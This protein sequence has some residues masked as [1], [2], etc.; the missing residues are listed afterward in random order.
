MTIA[1]R[2]NHGFSPR[3]VES[4]KLHF[5]HHDSPRRPPP[6]SAT[7]LSPSPTAIR[8]VGPAS[9]YPRLGRLSILHP[10]SDL[11]VFRN[12]RLIEGAEQTLQKRRSE[13]LYFF[14]L[15]HQYFSFFLPFLFFSGIC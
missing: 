3:R 7:S 1:S 14:I 9:I 5:S 12:K 2:F 13:F 8:S 6:L 11:R 10:V 15:Q 4:S